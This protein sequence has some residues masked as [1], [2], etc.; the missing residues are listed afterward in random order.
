MPTRPSLIRWLAL[1]LLFVVLPCELFA[2][3]ES[4]VTTGRIVGRVIDAASG[5]GIADA[6]VQ[7]VGTSIGVRSGVD[8]RFAI[9]GVPAGTV[10]IQVRRIG[11]ATKQVTG[12]VLEAGKSLEQSVSL[13]HATIQLE[14][15]VTTATRERGSVSDALDA[16]RT[17]VGVVSAVTAEQISKS[18][19]G[20]AA[21]AVKRVSGVTVQDGKYVFVRGLGERYTTSSLNGARVPSP[22]PER[23]V[24]PL[25]MFPAGLLQTITTSKT[26]T[27]D[28]QGDFSGALVNI[29]TR[30]FPA[31]QSDFHHCRP[32]YETLAGWHEP[33]TG[34]LPRAARGYVTFV[35]EALG[36]EISLVGTGAERESVVALR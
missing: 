35:E 14:T 22:E 13:T 32:I 2:Q 5:V 9:A 8:G 27:P 34:D 36:V 7:V 3:R 31:H 23:R 25:D 11:F 17:A 30:E 28:L 26:F 29:K 20:D 4:Q 18:P 19:D 24:V 12:L 16:Q 33:L 1:L 21:Q 15:Q 6:G 10:A